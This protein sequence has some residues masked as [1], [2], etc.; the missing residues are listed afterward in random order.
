MKR[1]IRIA[2]QTFVWVW[3][4]PQ[5]LA[6]AVW[7]LTQR[8]RF[9][10]SHHNVLLFTCRFGIGVSFGPMT[11]YSERHR[12]VLLSRDAR[13]MPYLSHEYGHALDSRLFGP[14]YL[15]VIGIPSG[16]WLLV[17]RMLKSRFPSLEN[18]YRF[19]TERRANRRG[20]VEAVRSRSGYYRLVET[21]RAKLH[22]R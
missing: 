19:Y 3:Q 9:L 21:N 15:F 4:L 2:L 6:G 7:C 22:S 10:Y 12:A 5:L 16:V 1:T 17:R 11:F 13:V 18:Y 20:G 8:P 14:L